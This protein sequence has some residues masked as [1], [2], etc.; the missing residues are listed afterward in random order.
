[1]GASSKIARFASFDGFFAAIR[2]SITM[3][4]GGSK[5]KD[6]RCGKNRPPDWTMP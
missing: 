4:A 5:K 2:F 3:E 1:M 6:G